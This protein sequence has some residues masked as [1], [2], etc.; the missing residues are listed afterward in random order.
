EGTSRTRH[1]VGEIS[2]AATGEILFR[3]A[4]QHALAAAQRDGFKGHPAFPDLGKVYS[5]GVVEAFARRVPP[6]TRGDFAA[7]LE[8]QRLPTL[9]IS[10]LALLGYS[11]AKLPSDGFSLVHT[12]E[13]EPGPF[14]FVTEVAGFRHNAPAQGVQVS[15]LKVG[16]PVTFLPE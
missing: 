16:D 10:S 9:T 3:Y 1:I 11:G 8:Q 7:Y 12:F 5:T 13:G 2:V 15:D 6:S 14:E 4:D